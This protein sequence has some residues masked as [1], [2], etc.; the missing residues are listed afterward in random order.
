MEDTPVLMCDGIACHKK[1]MLLVE[2][3]AEEGDDDMVRGTYGCLPAE[4]TLRGLKCS[5]VR[6]V[7]KSVALL[8]Q[9]L[10]EEALEKGGH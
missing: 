4:S 6:G 3:W 5:N 9:S 2:E 1:V 8:F 10:S 7:A